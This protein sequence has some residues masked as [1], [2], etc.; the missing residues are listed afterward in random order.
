MTPKVFISYSWA[1]QSHQERVKEWA[2]RL[3]AD[4]INVVLDL[5]DLKEG[6]DKYAFME[7][8]VTD[9]EVTHVLVISDKSYTDK[10]NTRRKGVGTESQIISKEVY[11]KV[12][13]SK[14]I[15]IVC[16][17]KDSDNPCLP[18]FLETR[19]W[20]DFS[21]PEAV[22][23]NWERLVRLLYGKPLHEKPQ[24]GKAPAFITQE[25][26]VPSTPA[27]AKFSTLRQAILQGKPGLRMYRSEFLD[28]CIA[29]ADAMRVR[30]EPNLNNFGE[31]VLEDCAKLIPIRDLIVDWV[32]LE[33]GTT[34]SSDF[35]ESLIYLLERLLEIKARPEEVTTW[36][37]VWF[38]AA[39]LFVYETFLYIIASLIK[40]RAYSD[41]NNIYTSHYLRPSTDRYG[42][43]RFNKFDD[44]YS[45]SGTLNAVLAPK[46]HT[47]YSPA[48]AL[49][50]RHATRKD[51][52]FSDIIQADLLTLLMAFI[53]PETQWYPQLMHYAEFSSEFPF[54]IRAA[55]HKN[56]QSLATITGI[57]DAKILRESV[58][59]G[60]KRLDSSRWHNFYSRNFSG[61]MNLENLDTI[62]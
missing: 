47:L 52:P 44:F 43:E 39:K 1:S 55:Q 51:L 23:S 57:A 53:T 33:A 27:L 62:K 17:F 16:D 38:E 20:I 3:L 36:N 22:N 31:K 54:F 11:E 41:L 28:Q 50:K 35:S 13:Q 8:M 21:S 19:I 12:E 6:Q 29:Y 61:P 30:K 58:L 2:D 9:A 25:S 18:V 10:A 59:A 48:A 15:P 42:S 46:G 7:R 14:F 24:L 5:Y 26:K 32:L 40:T 45:S 60:H 56:F 34:P 49:I 4:G 37:E